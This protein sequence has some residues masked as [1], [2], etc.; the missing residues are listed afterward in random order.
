M[1]DINEDAKMIAHVIR[2]TETED[3]GKLLHLVAN[4]LNE[5]SQ[6]ATG[7]IIETAA[8]EY[9]YERNS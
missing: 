8:Q 2:F 7:M 5:N 1:I 4:E 9:G 6:F 3:R